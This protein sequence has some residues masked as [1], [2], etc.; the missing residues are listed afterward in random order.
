[1]ER[2]ADAAVVPADFEWDD[3]GSWDALER[4]VDADEDGNVAL[5]DDPVFVDAADNVVATDGATVSLVGVSDLA[6]VAWGDRVL[7]VPKEE[8]QKVR[9]VVSRL[10][11]KEMF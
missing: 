7:V 11:R 2:A 8:A 10:K 5:G 6:V 3:L 4:I 1:M 9:E